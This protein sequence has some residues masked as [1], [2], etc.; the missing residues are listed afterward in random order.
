MNATKLVDLFDIYGLAD[1][2][3]NDDKQQLTVLVPTNEALDETMIPQNDI[4][5]WLRYHIIEHRYA[6][7]ELVDGALLVTKAGG[8]LLGRHQQQRIRVHVTVQ[9]KSFY[10]EKKKQSIQF[11][12]AVVT[13]E[14]VATNANYIYPVSK[15]VTLPR[16]VLDQLPTH[17][18]LST[19]V[20][21]AYA[22]GSNN[23]I[24]T[25]K[26]ITL[27]VPTNDAFERLGMLTKYLLHPNN[28]KKLAQVVLFHAIQGIYYTN[29]EMA[30]GEYSVSTLSFGDGKHNEENIYMNKTDKGLF[31]RGFGAA[32]GN[33]RSVIGKVV[34]E[35]QDEDDMLIKN[36]V[37]HKVDRVQL[38]SLLKVTNH[39]LLT[40]SGKNAFLDLMEQAQ[41]M[42]LLDTSESYSGRYTILAPSDRAFAKM[43]LTR[44]LEDQD[45]LNRVARLHILPV[46]IPQMTLFDISNQQEKQ[47][48]H[49]STNMDEHQEITTLGTEFDTLDDNE[50][51]MITLVQN[52]Q[53][54]S[55]IYTV[56]VKGSL[57]DKAEVVTIGRVTNGGGVI[58]IDRVLIP[59]DDN[60]PL[61]WWSFLLVVLSVLAISALIV[62]GGY[63]LWLWWKRRREGYTTL[64]HEEEEVDVD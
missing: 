63:Y 36:G 3:D 5:E 48:D 11:G 37:V 61:S 31:L 8:G 26:G 50:K 41:L 25:A 49:G 15:S 64:E 4:D 1:Y 52:N 58:E 22:S 7:E 33:D 20:A 57:Q 44:L 47:K 29:D 13:G 60:H 14:P 28:K 16:D 6:P 38:P 39:D 19:F 27:F 35:E 46:A 10:S 34:M 2:L 12:D 30:P 55:D 18:D 9:D 56:H 32:D 51:V 62:G 59:S 17:L 23:V 45:L 43:N 42:H 40:S 24:Q 21:S 54:T 53:K